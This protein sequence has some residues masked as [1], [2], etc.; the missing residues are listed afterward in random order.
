MNIDD[1]TIKELK[2]LKSLLGASKKQK[3]IENGGVRIVILQRGWVVVGKFSQVGSECRLENAAVI[4]NWGTT[5]GIGE[6]AD[7]GPT[8]STKL[9]ESPTIVFH[10]M[11][12]VAMILCRGEKWA[13]RLT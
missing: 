2:D 10:E 9:D 5:K 1:L 12:V 8:P 6:I 7:G 13:S 4:R 3:K 11:A